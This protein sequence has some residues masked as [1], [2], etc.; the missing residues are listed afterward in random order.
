MR[1]SPRQI[2]III[3]IL[4]CIFTFVGVLFC[5]LSHTRNF[6]YKKASNTQI[7]KALSIFKNN[8]LYCVPEPSR[9][10]VISWAWD[11]SG[12]NNTR[13]AIEIIFGIAIIYNRT[14]VLPPRNPMVHISDTKTCCNLEDF[15]DIDAL[16]T[17][18]PIITAK[19][20]FGKDVTY[21]H[22][23]KFFKENNG[24]NLDEKDS[25]N[26][27]ALNSLWNDF[28]KKVGKNNEKIWFLGMRMFS[29]PDS[30]F[31]NSS[32]LSLIRQKWFEGFRFDEKL[33]EKASLCLEEVGLTKLGSYNALH[34]RR[35][36]F[37]QGR[38]EQYA[39]D[40]N[41]YIKNLKSIFDVNKPLI[42]ITN[43]T[44]MD[45]LKWIKDAFP[46]T[47]TLEKCINTHDAKTRHI[48]DIIVCIAAKRF[49]GTALSTFS[50]YIQIL[51]GYISKYYTQIDDTPIF[52][53]SKS[54]NLI[55]DKDKWTCSKGCWHIIDTHHWKKI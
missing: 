8:N 3:L 11:G 21:D 4:A 42:L 9:D 53:Q 39:V 5:K 52:I 34:L 6:Y 51:R 31:R 17:T 12:F 15:Y 40:V 28:D 2:F 19:E 41:E 13:M 45:R 25:K 20:W 29:N 24:L 26:L 48:I 38:S 47:I 23:I 46:H 50:Y 43:E 36:D 33:L 32:Q 54:Q 49:I 18:F 7:R 14:L 55:K 22:Y 10:K 1:L 37:E 44:N 27:E 16:R 35:G 30:Y